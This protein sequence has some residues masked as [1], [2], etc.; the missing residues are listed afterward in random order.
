MD[1]KLSPPP[2]RDTKKPRLKAPPGACDTH[3]HIYGPQARFPLNEARPLDVEDS[4]VDDLI[5]LHDT[6]GVERGVI[7]QSLMQGHCY[8]YML[9]AL[10]RDPARFR[11]IAMPAPDITDRELEILDQ[12][13]VVGARFAFRWSPEIDPAMIARVHELGWHPQFWFRGEEEALAWRDTMLASPGNFVIDHMGWQP[14]SALDG[15]PYADTL[16]FAQALVDRAPERLLWGSD[17]PHPDHF[18]AMPND[19]DLFD[20]ML[21]WVP[22]P[23]TRKQ[24]MSDNPAELFGFGEV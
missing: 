1:R 18:E 20:L 12:A 9:N 7:V 22:D 14:A 23:A 19:G 16:P 8:E 5:K 21:D 13:G 4:T 2:V 15:P 11:G 6:L 17:W 3:F 10:C 24:I